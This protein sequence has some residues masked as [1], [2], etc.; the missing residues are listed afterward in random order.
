MSLIMEKSSTRLCRF[1]RAKGPYGPLEGGGNRWLLLD[2]AD[3]IYWCIKST[4]AAGPDNGL[5]DPS[6]CA[7]GRVCYEPQK[8]ETRDD[9]RDA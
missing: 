7:Q 6:L 8:D 3:T 5:V 2:D 1:F 9:E 4:G